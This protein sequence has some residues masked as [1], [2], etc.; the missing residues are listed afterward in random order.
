MVYVWLLLLPYL[1]FYE[2]KTVEPCT[3]EVLRRRR[4]RLQIMVV[5]SRLEIELIMSGKTD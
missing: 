2:P 4:E 1:H 5:K 3:A